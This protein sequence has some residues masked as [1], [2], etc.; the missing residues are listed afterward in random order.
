METI[1]KR[2]FVVND[3]NNVVEEKE[4]LLLEDMFNDI[5]FKIPLLQFLLKKDY[6]YIGQL[7]KKL[8]SAN[9]FIERYNVWFL[10]I[11]RDYKWAFDMVYDKKTKD[12]D[13]IS[14]YYLDGI[15]KNPDREKTYWKRLY[16]FMK[17]KHSYNPDMYI[18]G[19]SLVENTRIKW[20]KSKSDLYIFYGTL[21]DK[22]NNL[23]KDIMIKLNANY[24]MFMLINYKTGVY[25]HIETVKFDD[26]DF[27]DLFLHKTKRLYGKTYSDKM[28]KIDLIFIKIM[29]ASSIKTKHGQKGLIYY[30]GLYNQILGLVSSS[31]CATCNAP[32]PSYTCARCE[33]TTYCDQ[34]CQVKDWKYHKRQCK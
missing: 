10:L 33:N 11:K 29:L 30:V 27:S 8:K 25:K 31:I 15:S 17:R 6:K 22:F 7:Q 21:Y 34:L 13:A 28:V 5:Q 3:N 1:L 20:V 24:N 12:M 4:G 26:S 32:G 9:E 14:K 16:E 18:H 23:T 19:S 2:R